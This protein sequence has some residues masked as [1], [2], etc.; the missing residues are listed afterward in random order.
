M[1]IVVILLLIIAVALIRNDFYRSSIHLSGN[2]A[3]LLTI[4]RNN[5]LNQPDVSDFKIDV[6]NVSAVKIL[7]DINT[8]H[9]LLA[10][11]IINCPFDDGVEYSFNFINPGLNTSA[12]ATGC[13]FV[14]VNNQE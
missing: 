5:T 4:S 1:G 11:E 7:H 3:T 9:P 14:T 13:Q 8:L 2:S 10:G 6:N 12:S